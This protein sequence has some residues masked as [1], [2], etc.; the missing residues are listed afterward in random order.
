MPQGRLEVLLRAKGLA[1][2]AAALA[3]VLAAAP[4]TGHPGHGPGTAGIA[5]Y[6]FT[7][8]QLTVAEGD[9]VIWFWNGPDTNHSITS[10]P[11]QAEEFDSDPNT[12]PAL[13]SHKKN[14]AFS[15]E[16]TKIGTYTYH[17][18]VHPDAMRASVEVIEAPKA[19]TTKPRLTKLRVDG[20]RLRYRISEPAF[21]IASLR[22]A[23][24][25]RELRSRAAFV[26]GGDR[27]FGILKKLKKGRYRV[28]LTAEDDAGNKR[29]RALEFRAR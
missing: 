13:V 11:N 22:R 18:K 26:R 1:A 10:D 17:C 23:G 27:S 21:V 14:D 7:P 25:K 15:Y 19:D 4:A 24:S 9:T 20:T 2:P 29:R 6:A 12:A 28:T 16:F 8:K 5:D 3:A